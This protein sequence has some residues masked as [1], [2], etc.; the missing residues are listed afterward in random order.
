M[1]PNGLGPVS[2]SHT[3]LSKIQMTQGIAIQIRGRGI[4][5]GESPNIIVRELVFEGGGRNSDVL[6]GVL[7]ERLSGIVGASECGSRRD[8]PLVSLASCLVVCTLSVGIL[9]NESPRRGFIKAACGGVNRFTA[10]SSEGN[11]EEDRV[12]G[13]MPSTGPGRCLD[14]EPVA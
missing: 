9:D 12:D 1:S 2:D 7:S 8:L 3:K 10:A 14:V 13:W 5:H 6:D 11:V 4:Y